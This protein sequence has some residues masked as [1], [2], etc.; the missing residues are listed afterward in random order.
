MA[1]NNIV[2]AIK[3][4]YDRWDIFVEH[5][6]KEKKKVIIKNKSGRHHRLNNK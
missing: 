4:Y 2:T 1:S 5:E 6:K 3:G